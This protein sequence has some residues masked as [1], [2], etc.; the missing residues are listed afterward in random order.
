MFCTFLS[1]PA[2]SLPVNLYCLPC[3][4]R[5][6]RQ[7]ARSVKASPQEQQTASLQQRYDAAVRLLRSRVSQRNLAKKSPS[8]AQMARL[9]SSTASRLKQSQIRQLLTNFQARAATPARE[10][11]AHGRRHSRSDQHC[12]QRQKNRL[13]VSV[14]I[15][16]AYVCQRHRAGQSPSL[17]QVAG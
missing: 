16:L 15:L 4:A 8:M 12:R 14:R 9:L 5:R 13:A 6:Y 2:C 3:I 1:C 11:E 17:A 10:L 7:N